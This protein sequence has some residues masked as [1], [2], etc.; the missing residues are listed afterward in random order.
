MRRKRTGSYTKDDL[1]EPSHED[2]I[3][4]STASQPS[5]EGTQAFDNPMYDSATMNADDLNLIGHEITGKPV[6]SKDG[7]SAEDTAGYGFKHVLNE[8]ES[9]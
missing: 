5:A 3:Y 4:K 9:L 1:L 2:I 8:Y 7:P 6:K